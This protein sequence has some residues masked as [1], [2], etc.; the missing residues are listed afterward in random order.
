[1]R[2]VY[3]G[4]L[5]ERVSIRDRETILNTLAGAVGSIDEMVTECREELGANNFRDELRV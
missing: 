4:L 3:R 2:D 5:R 1:L